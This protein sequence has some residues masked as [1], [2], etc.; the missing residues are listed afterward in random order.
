[1]Y[2]TQQCHNLNITVDLSHCLDKLWQRLWAKMVQVMLRQV[3]SVANLHSVV[4]YFH[5]I[6]QRTGRRK[7]R[8]I[9]IY[10]MN[11]RQQQGQSPRQGCTVLLW[12]KTWSQSQKCVSKTHEG[13]PKTGYPRRATA[14]QI[15]ELS[16]PIKET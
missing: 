8:Q 11:E 3:E 10:W 16:S 1:M 12:C 7:E 9:Q 2:V 5:D 4:K 13:V 6:L 14:C 15:F